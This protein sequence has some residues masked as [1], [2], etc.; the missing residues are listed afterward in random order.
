MAF[1]LTTNI[2][3][4]IYLFIYLSRDFFEYGFELFLAV[5]FKIF[6][7]SSIYADEF[8]RMIINNVLCCLL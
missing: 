8:V 3:L 5:I 1:I 4:F 2:R 7:I 6:K